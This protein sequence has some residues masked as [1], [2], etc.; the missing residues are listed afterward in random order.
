ME[1][2]AFND[3]IKTIFSNKPD[4]HLLYQRCGEAIGCAFTVEEQSDCGTTSKCKYC[5]LRRAALISY[6]DKKSIFKEFL[7]REFYN[8]DGKKVLKHL[9]FSTR[10]FYFEKEYYV[11]T[12]IDDI[13]E[14]TIMK[15][16]V[17]ELTDQV[18][19]LHIT[20]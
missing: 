3:S 6:T 10:P 12:I 15:E 13:T 2:Q 20:R 18:S 1:L 11:I 9:Q 8:S 5:V 7:S 17:K 4:E 14:L 19:K 16:K